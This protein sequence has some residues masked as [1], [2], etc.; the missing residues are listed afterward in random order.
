M[1]QPHLAQGAES[2]TVRQS[3]GHVVEDVVTLAELQ[4][5][6]FQSDACELMKRL[7]RPLTVLA[8]GALLLLATLPV[9]LLAIAAGLVAA[10]VP[11]AAAHG[12]VAVTSLVTVAGMTA[13]ALRRFRALPPAFARSQEELADNL[14]W[15]K[16]AVKGL[17]ARPERTPGD[18]R[19]PPC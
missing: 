17:D 6:L 2:E 1:M 3:I 9:C 16:D 5:R 18:D 4:A 12:L 13:W 11:Q 8:A 7:A 19:S 15:I 10:G 14:S